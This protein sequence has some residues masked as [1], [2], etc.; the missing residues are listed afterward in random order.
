MELDAIEGKAIV[1]MNRWIV[2]SRQADI[3]EASSLNT[4]EAAQQHLEEYKMTES[5]HARSVKWS[6]FEWSL[7]ATGNFNVKIVL[8]KLVHNSTGN[9]RH[10]CVGIVSSSP[11]HSTYVAIMRKDDSCTLRA[12]DMEVSGHRPIKEFKIHGRRGAIVQQQLDAILSIGRCFT[13]ASMNMV[14]VDTNLEYNIAHLEQLL[15]RYSDAD[16]IRLAADAKMVP[17][18]EKT[19][20]QKAL[21]SYK[22]D[23]LTLRKPTAARDLTR[24]CSSVITAKWSHFR[25]LQQLGVRYDEVAKED[26][27][28]SIHDYF[29]RP[30]LWLQY[31]C[32]LVSTS[33]L[34][35]IGKSSLARL[36]MKAMSMAK[37]KMAGK[38]PGDAVFGEAKTIDILKNLDMSGIQGVVIDDLKLCDLTQAQH[39][40]EDSIKSLFDIQD[41]G[42]VH[43]RHFDLHFPPFM[44]RIFTTNA[45]SMDDWICGKWNARRFESVAKTVRRRCFYFQI[46]E[47]FTTDE[48]KAFLNVHREPYNEEM[49]TFMQEFMQ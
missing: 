18:E 47:P 32:V 48:G 41:G 2:R 24:M 49:A 35:G 6:V 34:T 45:E 28:V 10:F 40:S 26:V 15:K 16:I 13:S 8:D 29:K 14:M 38:P 1:S 25:N 27:F 20:F 17:K 5:I 31:A 43:C 7:P 39:L 46:T 12:T 42:T 36:A 9:D 33:E 30:E 22:N 44:P 11:S 3:P 37:H 21:L 4:W 23:L 19:M